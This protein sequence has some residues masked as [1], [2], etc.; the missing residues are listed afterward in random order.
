MLTQS[1]K[2]NKALPTPL[3][4]SNG[5]HVSPGMNP[6][7]LMP[8]LV[9]PLVPPPTLPSL[10]YLLTLLYPT[11]MPSSP[12][13]TSTT[14]I[15]TPCLNTSHSSGSPYATYR[16]KPVSGSVLPIAP[17]QKEYSSKCT[18]LSMEWMTLVA[19]PKIS[20]LLISNHMV[21]PCV[22]IPQVFSYILPV[23]PYKSSITS[24]TSSLS[25]TVAPTTSNISAPLFN[26]G[27]QSKSSQ[28]L[29]DS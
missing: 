1:R 6:P 2:P 21:T 11:L 23:Q 25:M 3:N 10:N 26:C 18:L 4:P 28:S 5:A 20:S 8:S 24:T 27:T 13:S 7:L 17:S 19:S 14:F 22:P 29:T 9:S 15:S 16:T 12:P